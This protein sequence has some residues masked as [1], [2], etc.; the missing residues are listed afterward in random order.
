[1]PGP[2]INLNAS[3]VDASIDSV[4][5]SATGMLNLSVE[6]EWDE[7]MFPN[8]VLMDYS[9]TVY[10]TEN[11]SNVVYSD[12]SIAGLTVTAESVMVLPFTNYTVSVSAST[13]AGQ[14][15]ET[16]TIITSPEASKLIFQSLHYHIVFP[17][18]TQDL[19]KLMVL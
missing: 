9:V 10:Q 2:V 11:S 12:D 4:Y 13:S 14:G 5:N 8:G 1:M 19:V 18:V 6:I 7:P 16:T 17:S 3:F 15:E